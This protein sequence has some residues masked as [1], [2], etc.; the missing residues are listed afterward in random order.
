MP[1]GGTRRS[2]AVT[3]RDVAAR[4]GVSAMTVNRRLKHGLQSLTATLAELKPEDEG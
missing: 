4:A 2:G 3:I 1:S